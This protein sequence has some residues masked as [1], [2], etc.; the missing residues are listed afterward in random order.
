[1][2]G[3]K[4][5]YVSGVLGMDAELTMLCN[6]EDQ[7]KQALDNLKDI[8]EASNSSIKG[9]VKTTI[10][11]VNLEHMPTVNKVYSECKYIFN[12]FYYVKNLKCVTNKRICQVKFKGAVL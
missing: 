10:L 11:L 3:D 6:I 4:T 5:V 2:V 8:L 9:V 7:T 12:T 1:M